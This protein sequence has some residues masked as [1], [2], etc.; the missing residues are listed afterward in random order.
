MFTL[1]IIFFTYIE[2]IVEIENII[3]KYDFRHFILNIT[4]AGIRHIFNMFY[5]VSK[6]KNIY[7]KNEKIFYYF[8]Y[9]CLRFY[10]IKIFLK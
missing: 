9:F 8:F 7:L 10:F 4:L 3:Q 2:K 6:M 1:T 5:N